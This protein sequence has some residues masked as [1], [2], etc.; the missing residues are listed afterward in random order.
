[1]FSFGHSLVRAGI[2]AITPWKATTSKT[3]PGITSSDTEEQDS[4]AD[5]YY[6][7]YRDGDYKTPWAKYY[8]PTLTPLTAEFHDAVVVRRSFYFIPS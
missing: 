4:N 6:V 1:M 5:H 2:S 8:D 7:G 3:A